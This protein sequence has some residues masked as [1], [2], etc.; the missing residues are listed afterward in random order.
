MATIV[1]SLAATHK[2]NLAGSFYAREMGILSTGIV[3][4]FAL[5]TPL[6]VAWVSREMRR[7][8]RRC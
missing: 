5:S 6:V 8:D 2:T 7:G 4:T 3:I 1:K